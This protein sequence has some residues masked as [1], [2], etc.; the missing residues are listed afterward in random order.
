MC[1]EGNSIKI[2]K[3]GANKKVF[4]WNLPGRSSPLKIT[5][6]AWSFVVR[7]AALQASGK[8]VH[9][10]GVELRDWAPGPLAESSLGCQSRICMGGAS[11]NFFGYL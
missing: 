9:A 2:K 4:S 3:L 5:L 10:R 7:T 6:A 11:V 1:P 8:E